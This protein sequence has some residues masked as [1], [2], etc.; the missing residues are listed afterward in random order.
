MRLTDK[1][2]ITSLLHKK[3]QEELFMKSSE[4]LAKE[5]LE[6]MGGEKNII[7][8]THCATRLRPA[9]KDRS[10]VNAKAIEELDG[11]TGIVDNEASFQ[12]IIG[13]H[14]RKIYDA[15]LN[16][17]HGPD[18]ANSSVDEGKEKQVTQSG[19]KYSVLKYP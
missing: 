18:G 4:V 3:R 6:L 13:I 19:K 17:W 2:V 15:F 12:I 5:L 10:L 1:D 16:V 8:I 9:I 7:S 14:V 11:V